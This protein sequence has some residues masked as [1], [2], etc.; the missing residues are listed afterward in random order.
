MTDRRITYGNG[1]FVI[2]GGREGGGGFEGWGA[3]RCPSQPPTLQCMNDPYTT[4]QGWGPVIS[5]GGVGGGGVDG[6]GVAWSDLPNLRFVT[7]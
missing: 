2:S 4:D 3:C 7:D 1:G 6:G 5:G